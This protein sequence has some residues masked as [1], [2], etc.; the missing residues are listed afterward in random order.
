[1]FWNRFV[2]LYFHLPTFIRL[3]FTVFFLM[4]V[5]GYLIHIIEPKHFPTFFD[6]VWWAFV[7][8]S[9]VGYGDYVPLSTVGRTIGILLILAGGGLVTFYMATLS[10]GTIKHEQDLTKG[11]V[12]YKGA[13]HLVVI[14]W[15]E[16]TK[17]LMK[18]IKKADQQ[19]DVV[20]IDHSLSSLSYQKNNI[21]FIHGDPTSDQILQKANIKHAKYVAITA[22]PEKIEDEADQQTILNIIAAKGNNPDAHV[23]AEI[24]TEA[25]KKNAKRAGANGI[26]RSNRFMSSLFYQEIFRTTPIQASNIIAQTLEE[27]QFY[28]IEI[29]HELVGNDFNDVIQHY[30]QEEK[31]LTGIIRNEEL[32]IHPPFHKKLQKEDHLLFLDPITKH[33]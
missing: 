3:L 20:L 6:G 16:R 13:N 7:T 10:A 21:H 30:I 28:A 14:G 33:M 22:D 19:M 4:T 15:N 17:Q 12:S 29:P 8:G 32:F 27:Q 2:K 31:I 5:F 23:I 25:Q 18:M 24:L 1:M 9:T 11:R 26:I